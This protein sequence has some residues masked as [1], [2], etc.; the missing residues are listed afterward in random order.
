MMSERVV[1]WMFNDDDDKNYYY[2]RFKNRIKKFHKS[3]S[4]SHT[5]THYIST[6]LTVSVCFSKNEWF[7]YKSGVPLPQNIRLIHPWDVYCR[8]RRCCCHRF[9]L[10]RYIHVI[11]TMYPHHINVHYVFSFFLQFFHHAI[12]FN[13]KKI[14]RVVELL[15]RFAIKRIM[16]L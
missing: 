7:A 14:Q 9:S 3:N 6:N 1:S 16:W 8:R 12:F 15:I 5:H 2:P 4:L 10:I 11:I 13:E